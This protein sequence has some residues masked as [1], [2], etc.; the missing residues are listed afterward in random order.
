MS[1]PWPANIYSRGRQLL[2]SQLTVVTLKSIISDPA[3]RW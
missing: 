1:A 3:C 2:R